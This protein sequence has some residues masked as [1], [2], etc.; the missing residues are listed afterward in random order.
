[1]NERT[2]FSISQLLGQFVTCKIPSLK[3]NRNRLPQSA[4]QLDLIGQRMINFKF[5]AHL[6]VAE[7][8]KFYLKSFGLQQ[9]KPGLPTLHFNF[10]RSFK[11][12]GRKEI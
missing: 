6:K 5:G 10:L 1:M 11:F 4:D 9:I 7:N 12:N 8:R 2:P 3:R